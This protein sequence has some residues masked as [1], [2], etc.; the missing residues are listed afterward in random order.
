MIELVNEIVASGQKAIIFSNWE[1]MTEVAKYKL[2]SYNPAY[3]TGATKADERMKEVER[4]QNDDKCKVITGTIG[5]MGTG[6]NLFK[7]S[8]IIFLD[9]PWNQALKLQAEDR[10]HRIGHIGTT[11][12]I[13][14]CCKGTIDEKIHELVEKKGA[15]AEAVVNGKISL[16]DLNFLLS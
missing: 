13:T 3:I 12:V 11:N 14:L 6:L 9:E 16:D 4:F 2:K 15:I 7:A 1:S 10:A 8:Y 5:A